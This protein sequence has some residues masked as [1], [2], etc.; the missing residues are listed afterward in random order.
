MNTI[1]SQ[2]NEILV[3]AP[4]EFTELVRG[5]EDRLLAMMAPVVRGQSVVLDLSHVRRIDA[6]G[7]ASLI[8]I[9]GCARNAGHTFHVC[10]VTAHVE[11]ILKLVGL[12]HIL[13]TRE[14]VRAPLTEACL[15]CPAA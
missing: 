1:M 12:D 10:N 14:E 6:A 13:V 3:T 9:Y 8:S 2:A 11:E 15:E 5:N 4:A 7:I